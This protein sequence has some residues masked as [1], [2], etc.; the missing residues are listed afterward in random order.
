MSEHSKE[1]AAPHMT[2]LLL[3]GSKLN[4]LLT[5]EEVH[6]YGS[7]SFSDPD[8][9]RLYGMTPAEWYARGVRLLGGTAVEC[10]RDA[11]ADRIGRDVASRRPFP[12]RDV[13]SLSIP[14]PALAI[15]CTGYCGTCRTRAGSPS[16]STLRSFG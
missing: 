1:S 12:P 5:L 11:V 13:G 10:T 2:E 9:I 6:R 16:S 15:P 3:H 7:D 8:F 4:E 14:S